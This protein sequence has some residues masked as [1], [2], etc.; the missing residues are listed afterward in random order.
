MTFVRAARNGTTIERQLVHMRPD[1]SRIVST[2]DAATGPFALV[3][4]T[5]QAEGYLVFANAGTNPTVNV[6]SANLTIT[7]LDAVT[8]LEDTDPGS[9]TTAGTNVLTG[10][11]NDTAWWIA[12]APSG[13]GQP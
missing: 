13:A 11:G 3:Y 5:G 7:R 8:G 1:N 12:T 9:P 6:T 2:R 10:T 4:K